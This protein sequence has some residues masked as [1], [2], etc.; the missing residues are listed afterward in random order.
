MP[1]SIASNIILAAFILAVA[2]GAAAFYWYDL[3]P[4]QIRSS[5]AVGADVLRVVTDAQYERCLRRHG[6][7]H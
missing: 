5:C 4:R 2:L 3:R 7:D 1:R 6:L